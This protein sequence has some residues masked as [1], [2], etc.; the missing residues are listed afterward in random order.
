MTRLTPQPALARPARRPARARLV[1]P[2]VSRLA[3]A[4]LACGALGAC[5]SAAGGPAETTPQSGAPSAGA[6]G[7]ATTGSAGGTTAPRADR[8][9][10]GTREHVDLWLHGF[11]LLSDDTSAVPLFRRG[12]AA[13]VRAR[14]GNVTTR[15][16]AERD[17][18]RARLRV[19]PAIALDAQFVAFPFDS[20]PELRGGLAAL[21]RTGGD[22]QRA[23]N[24][25]EAQIVA[26]LARAFPTAA[27]R[28]WARV[29][30]EALDDEYQRFYHA[31]W[32]AEQRSRN[33]ALAAAD[34]IWQATT[35]RLVPF[36]TGTQQRS[37]TLLLSLPLGGEG[38]TSGTGRGALVAVAFPATRADAAEATYVGVH[39]VVGTLVNQAVSDNVTPTEQREGVAGRYVSAGQV[40]AGLIALQRFA[41]TLAS[42]YA[43][44]YLREAGRPVP[45]NAVAAL[46]AAFPLPQP[47]LAAIARG[48]EGASSGI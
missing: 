19:A 23:A 25:Q 45:A 13:A 2:V 24:Q 48:L 20:W 3:A 30:G 36:L 28:E 33:A 10:V 17:R 21:A 8:W 14:R 46:E 29:F 35:A 16:D 31:H 22:P 40:R 11:A 47:I 37:G 18:L 4:A 42:G 15:L 43:A 1:A 38:R 12:Y 7:G 32:L 6:P 39:E 9:Q 5:A 44:F 27:D 34:S 26:F 41:P